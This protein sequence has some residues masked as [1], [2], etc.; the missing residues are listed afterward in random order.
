MMTPEEYRAARDAAPYWLQLR[1]KAVEAPKQMPGVCIVRGA[2]TRQFRGPPFASGTLRLEVEC[3]RRGQRT[4]PGDEFRM[5]VE[6]LASGA[7]L[8]AFVE[9]R[10][11]RFVVVARQIGLVLRPGSEPTFTGKE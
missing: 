10:E 6:E 8:E 7:Y 3:K 4:P 11:K 5:E 2:V 9:S 1:I